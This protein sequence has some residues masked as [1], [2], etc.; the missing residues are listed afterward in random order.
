MRVS[1]AVNIGVVARREFICVTGMGEKERK[2]EKNRLMFCVLAAAPTRPQCCSSWQVNALVTAEGCGLLQHQ[3]AQPSKQLM[4][5]VPHR[6]S[7]FNSHNPFGSP[8]ATPWQES[9]RFYNRMG[10]ASFPVCSKAVS[11]PATVSMLPLRL[12][13]HVHHICLTQRGIKGGRGLQR[14]LSLC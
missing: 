1:A 4:K 9:P 11:A 14:R 7:L 5:G 8:P 6:R 10:A 13:A 2:K 3:V 12:Q